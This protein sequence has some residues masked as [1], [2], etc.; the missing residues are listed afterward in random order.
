M[1][2]PGGCQQL[3]TPNYGGV[4]LPLI[5]NTFLELVART[6]GFSR[7]GI[8]PTKFSRTRLRRLL[9]SQLLDV[10]IGTTP[11]WLALVAT[12]RKPGPR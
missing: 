5:E 11:G 10:K 1:F 2:R 12:G 6:K 9:E 3:S 4:T 7:K 8:H